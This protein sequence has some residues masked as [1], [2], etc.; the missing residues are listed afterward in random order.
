[1]RW[2]GSG[3]SI[4][5]PFRP[6][7]SLV[8]DRVARLIREEGYTGVKLVRAEEVDFTNSTGFT[9]GLPPPGRRVRGPADFPDAEV[10]RA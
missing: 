8:T 2:N 9:P 6:S 3:F 7:T 5:W 10:R 4:V 1:M